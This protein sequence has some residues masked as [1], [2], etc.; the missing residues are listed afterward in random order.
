MNIKMGKIKKSITML[1]LLSGVLSYSQ[2][3]NETAIKELNVAKLQITKGSKE[4][5]PTAGLA[6]FKAYAAKGNAIAMNGLGIIYS[7]GISVA[8]ND[9]VAVQWFQKAAETGYP[10]AYYNLALFYKEGVSVNKDHAK[11]ITYFEKAAKSGYKKAFLDWG[12]MVK[13]GLGIEKDYKLA[14]TI[15][16]QGATAGEA[17]CFYG[18]GYLHYK[19]F[20]TTQDY[21]KAIALFQQAADKNNVMG[22]YMLGYCYRNGYGVTIDTEKAKYWL[23]KAAGLGYERA[24]IELAQPKAENATPN[25]VKT[26]SVNIVE[27][28][29][30]ITTVEVPKK[31]IKVKQKINKD[32]ISGLYTGHLMRYDWSGQNILTK[33]PI[34][35]NLNQKGK[36]IIGTWVEQA[37]D[38]IAFKATIEEKAIVFNNSKIDRIKR[39]IEPVLSTFKFKHAKLQIL[40]N[41]GDLYIAGNLQLYNI[42]EHE[43]EKPMYIILERKKDL[44]N[45]AIPI[46][47]KLMVNPNPIFGNSFKLSFELKEKTEINAAIYDFAGIKISQQKITTTAKGPQ[48]QTLSLNGPAGNYILNLYYGNEVIK[49][50]LIKK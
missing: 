40:E 11:A 17:S 3:E 15:F 10:K 6:T 14:M 1:L 5:N 26:V 9:V 38:S 29:E 4:Y 44:N 19:G 8:V 42:K 13:D 50:I 37:G 16:K 20:G 28:L 22:M 18:Q 25:Q 31:L 36:A 35:V 49:T 23:N 21:N 32:D 27:D 39:D 30:K 24:K 33:T 34:E 41:K 45:V 7:K 48:E 12:E 47:S 43:N 2:T 46:V